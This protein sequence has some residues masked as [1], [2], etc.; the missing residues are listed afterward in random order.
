MKTSF[1]DIDERRQNEE[2]DGKV[3]N[4][5]YNPDNRE[6]NFYRNDADYENANYGFREEISR[7]KG[8]LRS[9]LCT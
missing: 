8:A 3:A 1:G 4:G 2:P 9:F 5:Y 7:N 6:V